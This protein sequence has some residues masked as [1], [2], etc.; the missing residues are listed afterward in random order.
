MEYTSYK[1]FFGKYLLGTTYPVER[2]V[3]PPIGMERAICWGA[4]IIELQGMAGEVG[5]TGRE[6]IK[7]LAKANEVR[8]SW[9]VPP[10]EEYELAYPNPRMNES[11]KSLL[12]Q[13]LEYAKEIGAEVI[14]MHP[15]Q[16]VPRQP[17]DT[18][19]LWRNDLSEMV[20]ERI[21]EFER[22]KSIREILEDRERRLKAEILE[23]IQRHDEFAANFVERIKEINAYIESVKKLP[24]LTEVEKLMVQ[25]LASKLG[26]PPNF[27][28]EREQV[29]KFLERLE[30][31]KKTYE[32]KLEVERM[33]I[34][35]WIS[36]FNPFLERTKLPGSGVEIGVDT[37]RRILELGYKRMIENF[38]QNIAEIAVDAIKKGIK[39]AIE[40]NDARFLFS[41]P[42]EMRD[43]LEHVYMELEK[44]GVKREEAR[45]YIGTTFDIGHAATLKPLRIKVVDPE[46]LRE[47][48][49]LIRGPVEYISRLKELG[50]PIVHVHAHENFGD[51]DAHLP[52]GEAFSEE[53]LEKLKEALQEIK[54]EGFI[55]HE[56]GPLGGLSYAISLMRTAPE[57][58][59]TY[60]IPTEILGGISYHAPDL[61][62]D[63]LH[64]KKRESYFYGT[65]IGDLF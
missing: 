21:P 1:S 61:L 8:L 29:E 25:E 43:L 57:L 59:K 14:N 52:V 18:I 54:F 27:L 50:V 64:F 2:G 65:W 46:T 44:R 13:G 28:Q 60:G 39:I 11:A 7:D 24:E 45:K 19:Y 32:R 33:Y 9:H 22:E 48:E 34:E 6:V 5:K 51:I 17:P 15:T 41:T 55:L 42:E 53:E 63:P 12:R 35:R 4:P 40:N 20:V 38:A 56:P 31:L 58:Y 10:I 49:V 3:T 36:A 47:K 30:E 16:I 26:F 37:P 23:T 62:L